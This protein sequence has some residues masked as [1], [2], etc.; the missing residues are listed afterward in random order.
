MR[1]RLLGPRVLGV[2][3]EGEG[4]G[5]ESRPLPTL[6][7]DSGGATGV[8]GNSQRRRTVSEAPGQSLSGVREGL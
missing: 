6:P 7:T 1:C 4:R 2:G 8:Q 3:G 5:E